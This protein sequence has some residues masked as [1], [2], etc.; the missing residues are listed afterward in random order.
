MLPFGHLLGGNLWYTTLYLTEMLWLKS[1]KSWATKHMQKIESCTFR[2]QIQDIW[3]IS[4]YSSNANRK[5]LLGSDAD[6]CWSHRWASVQLVPWTRLHKSSCAAKVAFTAKM[7]KC[8]KLRNP[9]T[10]YKMLNPPK[11]IGK[12]QLDSIW[13]LFGIVTYSMFCLVEEKAMPFFL[14]GR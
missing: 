4:S 12:T 8:L 3:V 6:W 5:W 1:L 10:T 7:K 13:M 9:Q 11:N 14:P 2:T